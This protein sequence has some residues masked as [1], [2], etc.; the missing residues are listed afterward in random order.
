MEN[1]K[2]NLFLEVKKCL[3]L[4]MALADFLWSTKEEESPKTTAAVAVVGKNQVVKLHP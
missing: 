1:Y 2:E 3:A 4:T